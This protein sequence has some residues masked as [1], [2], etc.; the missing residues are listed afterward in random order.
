MQLNNIRDPQSGFSYYEAIR[1]LVDHA[2]CRTTPSCRFLTFRSST[3]CSPS[4]PTGGEILRYP[5][6]G[7]LRICRAGLVGG[8]EIP[9]YTFLQLLW[10]DSPD[11]TTC[12]FGGGPAKIQQHVLPATVCRAFGV[13]DCCSFKLQLAAI[14]PPSAACS[15][16]V[17]FDFNYTYGHS[18]DNASGLAE[19]HQLR[20]GVYR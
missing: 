8:A 13:L 2:V 14:K 17:T 16:D 7:R 6:S 11:C 3:T 9:D 4:C 15:N 5:D 10:D 12:P 19:L 1:P 18:L 20:Y